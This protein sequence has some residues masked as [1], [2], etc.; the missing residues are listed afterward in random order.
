MTVQA[1]F[2][3]AFT[4]VNAAAPATMS[5]TH[6]DHEILRLPRMTLMI[7]ARHH[8]LV[9]S[10]ITKYC[11][12][13]RSPSLLTKQCA[14]VKWLSWSAYIRNVTYNERSNR[15]HPP[16]SPNIA[17]AMTLMICP[18]Y[19][20][21][22][23]RRGAPTCHPPTSPNT[24]PATQNNTPKSKRNLPRSVEASFT[25]RGRCDH[26]PSMIRTGS[27][28]EL[29]ISHPPVRRAYFLRFGDAFCNKNYNISR[30]G[31][32]PRFHQILR[33]PRKV[34][35]QD[36]Q[37]LRLPRYMTLMIDVRHIYETLFTMRG[38]TGVIHQP[39]QILR[40]PRK[41]TLQNRREIYR[42][43]LKRDLQ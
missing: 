16:T 35:L 28:H 25:M 27:D 30:S 1:S 34:T 18:T 7:D 20:T 39:H 37:K 9:I 42:K 8:E 38:A 13:A 40:L 19:E 2:Y 4:I 33:L 32:L 14:C 29:V 26:D 17:P 10:N 21:S 3:V 41:I 15:H 24:A 5:P 23:T 6:Q 22:F 43:Q 12:H 36:H 11:T 31:Y